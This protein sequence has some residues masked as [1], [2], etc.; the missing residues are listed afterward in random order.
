[1]QQGLQLAGAGVLTAVSGRLRLV[2]AGVYLQNSWL[3]NPVLNV[4]LVTQAPQPQEQ[5]LVIF[6][7]TDQAPYLGVLEIFRTVM[8]AAF[9]HLYQVPAKLGFHRFAEFARCQRVQRVFKGR[10]G[11]TLVQPAKATALGCRQGVL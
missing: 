6:P 5:F 1:M 11:V 3:V 2:V 7:G 10:D 4:G 8:R 9:L